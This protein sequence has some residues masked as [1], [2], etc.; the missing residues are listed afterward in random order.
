MFS[1]AMGFQMQICSIL[2][3]SWSIFEMCIVHLQMRSNKT[4][5]DQL[6]LLNRISVAES[7][8]FLLAKRPS[9]AISEE[10]R[11]PFAGYGETSGNVA[12]CQLFS[13][14]IKNGLL[15]FSFL[16]VDIIK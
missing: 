3:F 12:K 9:A 2:R 10:K 8:T 7:Q 16:V 5:G 4:H 6:A 13:Q 1:Q 15:C 11:L 14:A